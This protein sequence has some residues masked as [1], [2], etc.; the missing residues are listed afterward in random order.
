MFEMSA[1][2]D[3]IAAALSKAQ[4][5]FTAIPKHGFNPQF[6][7]NYS[8]LDDTIEIPRPILAKHGLSLIQ[9][10]ITGPNP[11]NSVT[12]CTQLM[13]SSGQWLRGYLTLMSERNGP[14][15]VGGCVTYGRRYQQGGILNLSTEEDDDGNDTHMA[16]NRHSAPRVVTNSVP[17][18]VDPPIQRD[19][20]AT[21]Q[22]P[23]VPHPA[24]DDYSA[25]YLPYEAPH[26]AYTISFGEWKGKTFAEL[27]PNK[28]REKIL[29][30]ETKAAKP[31][32]QFALQ[33]VEEAKKYLAK[34]EGDDGIPF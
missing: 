10:P 15:V 14:Q 23:P 32:K 9:L 7:S 11:L 29:Y 6:K 30:F 13:H 34:V 20:F 31:L 2:I 25:P 28:I 33:F 3:K 24:D 1:E 19:P 5:E 18:K 12:I 16:G 17:P 27:A 22:E 4:A 8:K 21:T 26:G